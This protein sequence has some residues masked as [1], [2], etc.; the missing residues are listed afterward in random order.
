MRKLYLHIGHSKTGS[1]F[2]Q[3]SF[4]NSVAVMAGHGIDYPGDPSEAATGWKISSGNGQ[5]LLT[6]PPEAF[7][8]A[9]DRVFFSA[10]RLFRSFAMEK[11]WSARLA[12]FCACH[13]IGAVEVLMFL[14]D[15]IPHAESSYQQMVKRGGVTEGV[16]ATFANY[17]YPELVRDALTRDYGAVPVRWHVYN[18]DR[19]KTE[20][21]AIAERFLDL[22]AGV[23]VRGDD[24]PVNRSMTAAELMVLRG[25]N[26]HDPKAAGALADALCNEVPDV[27]SETV[28][29]PRPVQRSMLKRLSRA[30]A[31]VDALLDEGERYGSELRQPARQ[32]ERLFFSPRQVEVMTDVLGRRVGAV[33]QDMQLERVRRLINAAQLQVHKGRMAEAEV[34]LARA[35]TTLQGLAPDAHEDIVAL[36]RMVNK[37]R[38]GLGT[39]PALDTRAETPGQS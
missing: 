16:E 11:D 22:P 17:N 27:A 1:S 15:P 38:A 28:Y 39:Q 3:A 9:R 23:L 6:E 5:T 14:R 20:L 29:P 36:K 26:A 24:R 13:D 32:A 8:I 33:T 25:L 30:M 35:Q 31:Q 34:S 37:L 21:T 10:E 7:R 19:H 12:A 2:L 4:A 18:Y